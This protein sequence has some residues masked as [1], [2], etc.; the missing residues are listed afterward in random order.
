MRAGITSLKIHSESY[1]LCDYTQTS[2]SICEMGRTIAIL[3]ISVTYDD[4]MIRSCANSQKTLPAGIK[5]RTLQ[6]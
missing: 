5:T 6:A 2:E 3:P 4:H 1:L